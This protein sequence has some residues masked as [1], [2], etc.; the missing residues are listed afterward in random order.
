M[1]QFLTY[2]KIK[3]P[4]IIQQNS[5]ANTWRLYVVCIIVLLT[6]YRSMVEIIA[7]INLREKVEYYETGNKAHRVQTFTR[8]LLFP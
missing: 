8:Q 2:G 1:K 3:L 6:N 5:L 7:H 4:Q